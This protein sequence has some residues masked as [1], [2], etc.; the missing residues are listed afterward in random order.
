MKGKLRAYF[1]GSCGPNNPGGKMGIGWV[2]YDGDSVVGKYSL[3]IPADYSNTNN[4]AEHSALNSLLCYIMNN[5]E[6]CSIEIMGDSNMVINQIT[7]RWG[8]K[9]KHKYKKVLN[10]SYM[11]LG[12]LNSEGFDLKFRWI[13]REE[14]EHA[15]MLSKYS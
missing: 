4:I 1:D 2:I 8:A 5:L 11:V 14:N 13:P 9:S 12:K 3:T 15:D 6:P 7:R 10:E